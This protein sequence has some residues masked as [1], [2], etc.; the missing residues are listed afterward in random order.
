MSTPTR[1]EHDSMGE[2]RVPAGA[3]YGAST[4]RAVLNFPISGTPLDPALIHAYGLIK[5]A[6]ATVNGELGLLSPENADLIL[7]AAREVQQGK[8]DAHFPVDVFQTGSGTS[9]NMNVNEVIA[10]RCAQLAELPLDSPQDRK[11][12]HPNDHVNLG[13][14]SNDTFPTAIHLAAALALKDQLLPALDAL[15]RGLAAKA[16]AFH[17]VLKVGRTHLMD[18][19]PIRLGQEFSG[20]AKQ[21]ER[22]VDRSHKALKALH[23][24]PLGG[25]AVGTGLNAH[26]DFASRTI[27]LL[28]AETNIPFVEAENHFE[29]QGAR[30]A[31]VECHGQLNTIAV[32]LHKIA[33]D[34]RLLASGPRCSLGEISLPPTQPG[35][36]IMPGKVNPVLC[37][38]VTMVAARVF[39]NHTTVT[40]CGANGQLELNTYMPVLAQAVLESIRLL[41]NASHTFHDRCIAGIEANKERC[42]EL[43]EQSL[44]MVTALAPL[45]GYDHASQIAKESVQSGRTVR[46]LCQQHLA[47]LKLTAEQL[48]EALDPAKMAGE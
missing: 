23:E 34:L 20:Y 40:F 14:S 5:W 42:A 33:N 22:A 25:T 36:S 13:Q 31:L 41:A 29:A 11:P 9:T 24:L 21:I 17:E 26:P 46:E 2:M 16:T 4:Q 7:R 45:I 43:I 38:A 47:D 27:A 35:S 39:G 10:N 30:D 12:V 32:S 48:H 1:L 15:H 18:A 19:T 8:H 37:E 28:A 44:S 3:L 6:A